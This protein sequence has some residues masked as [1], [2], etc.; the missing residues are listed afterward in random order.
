MNYL[1]AIKASLK[2][3][4]LALLPTVLGISIIVL[5]G[6][7]GLVEPIIHA[8][9]VADPEFI[10]SGELFTEAAIQGNLVVTGVII[11]YFIHRVGRTALQI[12]IFG[13]AIHASLDDATRSEKKAIVATTPMVK[14]TDTD[15]PTEET[16]DD[17]RDEDHEQR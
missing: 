12:R 2:Y 3:N 16:T 5:T 14:S 15:T 13:E 4:I 1:R 6:W 8:L 9:E 11:G 10:L 17:A 7:T